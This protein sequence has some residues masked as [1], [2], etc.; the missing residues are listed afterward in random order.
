MAKQV[1]PQAGH[2][3]SLQ[4]R[5]SPKRMIGTCLADFIMVRDKEIPSET[6]Y[7]AAPTRFITELKKALH[8]GSAM[9]SVLIQNFS[10]QLLIINDNLIGNRPQRR[11]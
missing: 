8:S 6:G 3:D 5:I 1:R 9:C 2:T 7:M 11:V 4:G 10:P